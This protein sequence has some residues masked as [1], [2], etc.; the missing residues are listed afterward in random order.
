MKNQNHQNPFLYSLPIKRFTAM[1]NSLN[2]LSYSILFFLGLTLGIILGFLITS[3]R[4]SL[5]YLEL[6]QFSLSTPSEQSSPSPAPPPLLPLATPPPQSV[7]HNMEDKELLW[8]ASLVPRISEYP[9][10]RVPKVAFMFL[11]KGSLPFAPLWE[12]FFKGHEGLYS[13]YVHSDPSFNSPVPE[14]GVFLGRRIPS[15]E[16]EWGKF[17]MV[18]AELRLLANALLDVSNQRFV[19]LSESCIPLFNFPTIYSYLMNSKQSHV[20]AYD[21]PTRVARGRY[22]HHMSP[23]ITIHQWRKGSQWFET[24]RELAVEI[25]SDRKYFSLFKKYCRV[26]CYADEHYLPTLVNMKFGKKNSN[27]SLTWADWSKGGSHPVR[28]RRIHVTPELLER[29]RHGK[30]CQYNG[31]NSTTCFLFARK[32]L[33]ETL[34]RLLIFSN[35]VMHF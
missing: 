35:K 6:T 23:L 15:K 1:M 7:M 5:S 29:L 14:S 8:R 20:E 34:N 28:Y 19:L 25:I 27:R 11:T 22:K 4:F 31:K 32:F 16:V 10:K 17:S 12:K 3:H 26:S 21:R 33:P 18:E 13:I 30:Q 9:F 24:D 2:L